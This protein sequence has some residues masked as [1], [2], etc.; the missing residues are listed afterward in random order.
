MTTLIQESK[1][2]KVALKEAGYECSVRKGTGSA[3]CWIYV[4]I[5]DRAY[6]HEQIAAVDAIVQ[7][8]IGRKDEVSIEFSYRESLPGKCVCGAMGTDLNRILCADDLIRTV[9][10]QC[11]AR[12]NVL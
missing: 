12:V 2:I 5:R 11:G 6:T 4:V 10:R 8:T 1:S 3:R 7:K 9:C